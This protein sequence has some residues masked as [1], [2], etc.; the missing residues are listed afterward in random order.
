M[1]W[2]AR[3]RGPVWC[4]ALIALGAIVGC[5]W[6]G[7]PRFKHLPDAAPADASPPIAPDGGGAPPDA[8]PVTDAAAS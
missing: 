3:P 2:N 4:I 7:E 1:V 6:S 8:A 5:A